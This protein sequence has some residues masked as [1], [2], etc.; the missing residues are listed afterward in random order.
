MKSKPDYYYQQSA[1]VPVRRQG[2]SLQVLLISS[3]KGKRWIIPKGIVESGLSPADSA[4]KEAL[5]EAGIYG[6]V[7]PEVLGTYHYEKWGGTCVVQVYVMKVTQVNDEWLEDFRNRVWLSLDE[8]IQR[9]KETA[10]QN[11]ME[12]LPAFVEKSGFMLQ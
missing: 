1:V 6:V 10:L 3:R 5:E 8:A 11:M 2:D 7:L 12:T 9:M 4:T